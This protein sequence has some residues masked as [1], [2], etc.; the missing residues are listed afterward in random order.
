[1]LLIAWLLA[2]WP[3]EICTD[4]CLSDFIS[5]QACAFVLQEASTGQETD[6][7]FGGSA[8]GQ[9]PAISEYRGVGDLASAEQAA[10]LGALQRIQPSVVRIETVGRASAGARTALAGGV[11]TGVVV[12]P[13]GLIVASVFHFLN[14]PQS[15][16][17][18]LA[19]GERV[20]AQLVGRDYNRMLALLK[21]PSNRPLS[22][23]EG[24]PP[25][26]V[27][28]GMWTIAVG[29]T[30]DD[31]RPHA[32][33]GILSAKNR[34]WG[35][36]IQTDAAVSPHNYG[37]PLIDLWGRILG[38]LVPFSP[39][40]RDPLAGVE[41]YDSG[42]GFAVPWDQVLQSVERLREGEDL[43]AAALGIGFGEGNPILAPPI[44]GTVAA[45]SAAA[46]AGLLAGDRI[47]AVDRKLV[48][49]L[50]ELWQL[51][52]QRYAGQEVTLTI[53]RTGKRWEA[54]V[55]LD[56][57][58]VPTSV[59]GLTAEAPERGAGGGP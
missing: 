14:R 31:V 42:I 36:A 2:S 17:V 48:E 19:S 8:S 24:V 27:Q 11:G 6:G 4:I 21:V 3:V 38:V 25:D 1:V 44:V 28:V 13:D 50:S 54:T 45:N 34:I 12:S 51:L 39:D 41:W 16:L 37:G 5:R 10:I 53:E 43:F 7:I 56:R 55:V 32:A 18:R 23:P 26:D 58:P 30:W 35:K 22:V 33:V 15:I 52:A 9:S 40:G 20:S 49:R 47:V 46:R 59:P 29:W 57:V